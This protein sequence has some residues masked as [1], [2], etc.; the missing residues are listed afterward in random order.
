[1]NTIICYTWKLLRE[2]MLN[3]LTTEEEMVIMWYDGDV[4]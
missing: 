3:V 4:T 1:M 2:S